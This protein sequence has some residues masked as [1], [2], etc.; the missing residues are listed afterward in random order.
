MFPLIPI[1]CIAALIGGAGGLAWYESLSKDEQEK[2]DKLAGELAW[3]LYQK[4]LKNLS[5]DQAE[6][7]AAMVQRKMGA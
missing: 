2:A 1:L 7:V 5:R 6:N 4:S 3:N